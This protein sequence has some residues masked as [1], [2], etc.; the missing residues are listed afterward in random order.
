MVRPKV[1]FFGMTSCKG[2]YFQLL[3]V[4][5]KLPYLLDRMDVVDF[6]MLNEAPK[7]A[8]KYDIAFIDGAVSNH[9]NAELV[10]EV[11]EKAKFVIAFG[12]CACLGGIPAL[13]NP[14]EKQH[15]AYHKMVYGKEIAIKSYPHADPVHKHIHVDCHMYGC[16]INEHEII[17]VVRDVILGKKPVEPDYPVCVDCKKA[18]ISCLFKEGVPCL[19]PVSIAGCDAPCPASKTACD[20]CRGPLPDANWSEEAKLL[21]EHGIDRK[22]IDM[23]FSKYTG[24]KVK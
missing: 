3:L 24:E 19:G 18:G 4:N 10:R 6:W 15:N 23:M 11:R 13:R 20:G 5:E 16:P 17:E 8:D 14:D 9:E 12:T 2:C 1:A 21:K 7:K 22:K